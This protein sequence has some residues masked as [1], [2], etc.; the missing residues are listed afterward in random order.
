MRQVMEQA[1]LTPWMFYTAFPQI[2]SRLTHQNGD[3]YNCLEQIILKVM[4]AHPQH[5]LWSICPVSKSTDRTRSSR[6]ARLFKKITASSGRKAGPT[7]TTPQGKTIS[8]GDLGNAAR[9]LT[10]TLIRLC[11][12]EIPGKVISVRL[13]KDPLNLNPAAMAPV[14]MF[15]P[16]QQFFA[17]MMPPPNITY[18]EL[19]KYDPFMSDI[20]TIEAFEEKVE[21]MNSLQKPRRIYIRGSDGKQYSFLCKP[22][23]DLRKDQRLLEFS[24]MIDRFLKK[25]AE[26]HRRRLYIRTYSVTPLNEDSGLIEW[27]NNIRTI[28]DIILKNL[29][30]RGIHLNVP[31]LLSPLFHLCSR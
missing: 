15:I 6:G 2:I 14:D 12:I 11:R 10:D 16:S 9:K 29:S 25:D 26:S 21:V 5:A 28:R 20:P 1:T 30:Q 23:D 17:V 13:S 22:K 7:I 31:S 19:R 4:T 8:L 27:V 24:A 18:E 3:V